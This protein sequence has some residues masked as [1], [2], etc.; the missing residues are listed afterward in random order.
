MHCKNL[1]ML[2]QKKCHL[3]IF[4][5]EKTSLLWCTGSCNTADDSSAKTCVPNKTKVVN[6]KGASLKSI[7]SAKK[8]SFGISPS[9]IVSLVHI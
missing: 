6:T 9:V 4:Y 8:V 5:S 7:M 3:K 1:T 2:N